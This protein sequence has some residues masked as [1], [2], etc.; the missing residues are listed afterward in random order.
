VTGHRPASPPESLALKGLHSWRKGCRSKSWPWPERRITWPWSLR[1]TRPGFRFQRSADGVDQ[2]DTKAYRTTGQQPAVC[3]V[4]L[5]PFR[6]R[7][8]GTRFL[9][10]P[11]AHMTTDFLPCLQNCVRGTSDGVPAMLCRCIRPRGCGIVEGLI[12][13]ARVRRSTRFLCPRPRFTRPT[14][15]SG[16]AVSHISSSRRGCLVHRQGVR[17]RRFLTKCQ[18][19]FLCPPSSQHRSAVTGVP[20]GAPPLRARGHAIWPEWASPIAVQ[21]ILDVHREGPPY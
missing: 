7:P 1:F 3:D 15:S 20:G 16:C 17:Q 12:P 13:A 8:A 19:P 9:T 6:A 4:N 11:A 10:K 14:L 5:R 21:D 2:T 18:P